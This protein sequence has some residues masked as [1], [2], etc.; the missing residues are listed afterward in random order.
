M[1]SSVLIILVSAVLLAYWFRYTCLLILNTKGAKDYSAEVAAANELFFPGVAGRLS[2]G[3]ELGSLNAMLSRDYRLLNYLLR[4]TTSYD[5]GGLTIEQRLL[6]LDF[7][8]MRVWY[9][10]TSRF[11]HS[12]A[13]RAIEEMSQIVANFANAM[14]E[15]S[16]ESARV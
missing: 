11:A 3:E 1:V 14:G 12:Q 6:S 10:I 9:G 16:A 4:H 8:L 7:Q 5:A 15:R 13:R 2:Q